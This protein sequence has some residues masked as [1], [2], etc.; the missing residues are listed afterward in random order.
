[1][2]RYLEYNWELKKMYKIEEKDMMH[3]L[4]DDLREKLTVYING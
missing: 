4:N 2:K 1:M 3:L